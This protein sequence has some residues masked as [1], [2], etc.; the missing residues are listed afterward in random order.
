M[1]GRFGKAAAHASSSERR[2]FHDVIVPRMVL[3]Y[4]A[5]AIKQANHGGVDVS[6]FIGPNM[7]VPIGTL[8]NI[9]RQ[10]GWPWQTRR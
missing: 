2:L 10:A 8:R 6:A 3:M 9:F 4:G 1:R 7:D 5:R